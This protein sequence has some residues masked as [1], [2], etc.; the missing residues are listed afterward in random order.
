MQQMPT[1]DMLGHET[2][3]QVDG[4]PIEHNNFTEVDKSNHKYDMADGATNASS[5]YDYS[6]IYALAVYWDKEAKNSAQLT[7]LL[8]WV[9]YLHYPDCVIYGIYF[10]R[11]STPLSLALSRQH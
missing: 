11:H 10:L 6:V 9:V 2:K 7:S 1:A 3:Q 8:G 5:T 4:L